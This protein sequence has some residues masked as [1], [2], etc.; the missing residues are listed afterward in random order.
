MVAPILKLK[1]NRIMYIV[2]AKTGTFGGYVVAV[3]VATIRD[4]K[5]IAEKSFRETG[6][7]SLVLTRGGAIAHAAL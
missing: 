1:G 3:N 5:R 4:A 2:S 6:N 7:V